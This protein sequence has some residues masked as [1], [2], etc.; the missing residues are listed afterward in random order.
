MKETVDLI[1]IFFSIIP[2]VLYV[3]S[4]RLLRNNLTYIII[5]LLAILLAFLGSFLNENHYRLITLNPILFLVLY[6]IFDSVIVRKLKRHIYFGSRFESDFEVKNA[7]IID[8]TL[9]FIL[10]SLPFLLL[11]I[12]KYIHN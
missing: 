2:T 9:Q 10:I 6:K 12:A 8:L 7:T 11:A 1:S 3:K 5:M 4:H